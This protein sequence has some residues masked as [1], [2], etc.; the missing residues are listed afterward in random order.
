MSKTAYIGI[1]NLSRK[2]KTMYVG[3]EGI[4]RKVKKAYIGVDGVARE[5]YSAGKKAS[6]YGVGDSVLLSE[7]GK[8]VE[9]IVVQQGLPASMYD[10]SCNGT[11]L[12][13]KECLSSAR[14]WES[15]NKNDYANSDIDNYLNGT[16]FKTL[17]V[18]EQAAIKQVKIPYRKGAGISKT[19]TSGA[20]GL[21][22][23]VFLLSA[24]ELS[25][26]FTEI[27]PTNEG[28]ELSYFMG[29]SDK[30]NDN[31]RVC[32]VGSSNYYWWTRTPYCLENYGETEAITVTTNGG[33]AD[34]LCYNTNGIR[35]TVILNSNTNF[36]PE[37]NV[38]VG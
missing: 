28:A 4:A 17:G 7:N 32:K 38:I 31:K 9:Y 29:C 15:S 2:V 22:T 3:V 36:N 30:G 18:L 25:F 8:N 24:A 6:E 5:W 13:R 1:D 37:T 35:P 21:S 12:L 11:W 14:A 10:E 23:K 27:T 20:N 16:F 34:H 33:I 26:N 19:V